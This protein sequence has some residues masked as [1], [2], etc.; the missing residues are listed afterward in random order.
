MRSVRDLVAPTILPLAPNGSPRLDTTGDV[1]TV[2]SVDGKFLSRTGL[3][4]S[5]AT[6]PIRGEPT[7]RHDRARWPRILGVHVG[8]LVPL[9]FYTGRRATGGLRHPS[10]PARLTV[11][12]RLVGIV[13]FDN[14]VV[15]D[16]IDRAYGFVVVTPALL[17]Q[18][19]AISPSADRRSSTGSSSTRA[20]PA[21]PRWSAS[22]SNSPAGLDL[23]FHVDLA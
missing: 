22:S 11:R 20:G 10:G 7:D 16:D 4:P 1:T 18:A 13:V 14:Q 19:I 12:A 9:G 23:Q 6:S 3:P 8:Q 21:S 2:G 15:Q 5:R 17:D